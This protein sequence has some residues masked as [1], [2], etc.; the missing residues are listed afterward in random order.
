MQEVNDLLDD[1]GVA[2]S[3]LKSTLKSMKNNTNNVVGL[4]SFSG[5]A[6]QATKNYLKDIHIEAVNSY[7]EMIDDLKETLK[8]SVDLFYSMVDNENSAI[9]KST[10]V[11]SF[12][13]DL[14]K[15][16][17]NIAQSIE[18]VNTHIGSISDISSTSKIDKS[19][20]LTDFEK[21]S[22]I[23]EDVLTNMEAF[24]SSQGEILTNVEDRIS[25]LQSMQSSMSEVTSSKGGI[26][27]YSRKKHSAIAETLRIIR[28]TRADFNKAKNVIS[29]AYLEKT[30]RIKVTYGKKGSMRYELFNKSKLPGFLNKVGKKFSFVNKYADKLGKLDKKFVD[31][32][33][34][35]SGVKKFKYGS[36]KRILTSFKGTTKSNKFMTLFGSATKDPLILRKMN[37]LGSKIKTMTTIVKD[38]VKS[39]LPT[40]K[41]YKTNY[42]NWKADMSVAG[43]YSKTLKAAKFA[44]GVATIAATGLTAYD[45]FQN[46][47]EAGLSGAEVGVSTAVNTGI[48]LA[49]TGVAMKVGMAIGTAIFPGGGTI[50]GAV[51]GFVVGMVAGSIIDKGISPVKNYVKD[52]VNEGIKNISSAIGSFGKWAFG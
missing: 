15:N 11:E 49:T 37:G 10:Y 50:V 52:K 23:I 19:E 39:N 26:S 6:A 32:L 7:V 41:N 16:E 12:E 25:K 9:I 30:G 29:L 18:S 20:F 40:P 51:G 2:S 34:E 48:D 45:N 28:S 38:K 22:E 35:K 3:S 5:K 46:A 17:Q 8:S 13:K 27:N 24:S 47:R 42:K 44:G 36:T 43:K 31:Y 1:F 21:V 33:M 4:N 14:K